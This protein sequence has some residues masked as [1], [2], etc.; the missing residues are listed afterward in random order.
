M[1][2]WRD[3]CG[4]LEPWF[5]ATPFAAANHYGNRALPIRRPVEPPAVDRLIAA[6]PRPSRQTLWIFDLPAPLALWLA[7][8]LRRRWGLAAALAWNGWYDPRGLLAGRDEIPLLLSLATRLARAKPGVGHCLL[9]DCQRHAGRPSPSVLDNRYTLDEEDAPNIEQL[10]AIGVTH[11]R[12]WSWRAMAIDVK[13]Y[14]DYLRSAFPVTS[15]DD[16]AQ[17]LEAHA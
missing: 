9:F 1:R 10:T 3:G 2:Q 15:V 12:A 14:V 6:L 8:E 4:P 7:R 13:A 17:M 16:V 5:R 11:V